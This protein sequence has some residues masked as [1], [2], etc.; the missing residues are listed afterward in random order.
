MVSIRRHRRENFSL[1]IL[2]KN[3]IFDLSGEI[4]FAQI[5]LKLGGRRETE[6][7]REAA[8][9]ARFCLPNLDIRIT[10]LELR[11]CH[12]RFEPE[13]D[14]ISPGRRANSTRDCAS[15]TRFQFAHNVN[16]RIA[17]GGGCNIDLRVTIVRIAP[18]SAFE[19]SVSGRDPT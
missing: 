14:R 2:L 8:E 10:L 6:S 5:I 18:A 12:V 9:F 19:Q 13:T 15:I 3:P 4:R 1:R 17:T 11:A 7:G 16:G